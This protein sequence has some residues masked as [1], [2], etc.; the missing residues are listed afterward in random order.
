MSL[1]SSIIRW[2]VTQALGTPKLEPRVGIGALGGGVKMNEGG[3]LTPK[4]SAA[5]GDGKL[6]V[7][8]YAS[9]MN[10][11]VLIW[12]IIQ[13]A[14]FACGIWLEI[15]VA[16][17]TGQPPNFLRGAIIG[18]IA[19]FAITALCVD[20][21]PRLIAWTR[22]MFSPPVSVTRDVNPPRAVSGLPAIET[23]GGQPGRQGERLIASDRSSRD[24]PKLA[25]DRRI[26]Q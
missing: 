1:P 17:E 8:V 22:R 13:A 20:A 2:A 7:I 18:I 23:D 9:S 26:G 19:A 24:L 25:G 6:S 11:K 10:R 21:I 3:T 15:D 12:M 5:I 4:P 16:R 14:A